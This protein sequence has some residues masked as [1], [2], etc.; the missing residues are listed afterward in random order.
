[1]N[2]RIGIG[3]ASRVKTAAI[4]SALVVVCAGL[5][6]AQRG[7]GAGGQAPNP[8][9]AYLKVSADVVAITHVRV[10]DGTGAP[11]R[12]DQTLILKDGN[13]SAMGP[14]ASTPTPE[15]ATII[16]GTGKSVLP[17]LVMLHEHLYYPTGPGVYGQLGASFVR[18]Y[19]AGGVTTIR[20][21][22]NEN[23]FMDMSLARGTEDGSIVGPTI[24]A[25]A[26]YLNGP[27]P[28][29][30]QMTA[31]KNEAD[32]RRHVNY[33][34]DQ[35]ATSFKA[36]MQISRADLAASIDEAHKRGLKVTGHLCS[37]TLG[38]A[39]DMGI[40]NLEHGFA[41]ATDFFAN[42]QPDVCPGQTQGQQS[43]IAAD[44]NG[45]AV[46]ALIKKLVD[47][48]VALTSTLTVF[49]TFTPGRPMPPGID[50]LVPDLKAQFEASY[51]RTSNSQTSVYKQL[52]PKM[53]ALE[54]AFVRAGGLLVAG[55]DPTGSGGVI[56][57]YSNQR[58]IELLVEE[59][60]TPL[61]AIKV[62]TLNGATY[63]GRAAKIGSIAVGK[64]ADLML[65][66]GDPST[67]IGDVRKVDTVFRK[68]VGFD[69]VKL[70]DSVKGKV[71]IW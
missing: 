50:V 55:T 9:R 58:Q 32:A 71:G 66:T 25:T 33:W 11:A 10:I 45:D 70:I 42:K 29:S 35:G 67:T 52:F 36:Y 61:E 16:D 23:G 44:I 69:P 48:K 2:V 39:A 21:A 56:P 53:M 51:Q 6:V 49:E 54:L 63:L 41:A 57:G 46:K 22:G 47:K 26:P 40:D 7:Q 8:N 1:M 12:A 43:V 31:L 5:A 59:G 27:R 19:L 18:L 14:S 65:V 68:G 17:G 30:L 13:I 64:Q 24:D 20:T 28:G 4:V 37:V 15:G 62:A 34:A 38:E 60:L 3:Y